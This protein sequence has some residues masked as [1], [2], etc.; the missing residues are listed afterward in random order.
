MATG[1]RL[2]VPGVYLNEP[3][4]PP[5]IAA[6]PT[7]QPC[8]VGVT[9]IATDAGRDLTGIACPIDS[10]EAF[11]ARFC[12]EAVRR[13]RIAPV[14]APSDAAAVRLD[15]AVAVLPIETGGVRGHL[16]DAMRMY[17]ANGGGPCVIVSAGA[18]EPDADRLLAAVAVAA[19]YQGAT[20]IAVPD[21]VLLPA[22]DWARVALGLIAACARAGDRMAILDVCELSAAP[23]G[24]SAVAA[25]RAALAEVPAEQRRFG[26][27]YFPA[28]IQA[29]DPATI[30][31]SW[32]DPAAL[33]TLKTTLA[34]LSLTVAARALVALIGTSVARLEPA[35]VGLPPDPDLVTHRD[36]TNRLCAAIPAMR[37]LLAAIGETRR[38]VPPS[39]ALAGIW[40]R[41][42]AAHGVW[43]AP[44]DVGVALAIAP[45]LAVDATLAAALDAPD[46]PLAINPLRVFASRGLLVWGTRTLDN[47]S[48][49]WRYLA[50]RRTVTWIEQSIRL[51]LQQLVFAPNTAATWAS[52]ATTIEALL[53]GLWAAGGLSGATAADAFNVATGLGATMTAGDVLDGRMIVA[54]TVRL[55]GAAGPIELTFAQ[56]MAGAG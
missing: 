49:D 55:A 38:V 17:F 19:A 16:Y 15:D 30:D 7:A 51:G 31:L 25:F 43:T 48:D 45:T 42:D 27:A 13:Y 14:D 52:A 28:L 2:A 44:A 56:A 9:A 34:A 32:I 23:D 11:V 5:A 36:L 53:H 47:Q 41:S 33:D 10:F 24:T 1:A 54:V 21:A 40:C 6:V 50:V 37:H 22:A 18:G 35:D 8:F 4:G 20:A 46:Q 12:G 3:A 39:G 29:D 26:V